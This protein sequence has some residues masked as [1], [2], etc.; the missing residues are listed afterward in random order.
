[1]EAIECLWVAVDHD[2]SEQG[3]RASR[4]VGAR[5]QKAG[6]EILFVMPNKPGTDLN[7]LEGGVCHG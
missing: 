4:A 7:D 3:Q 5:W 1:M 2:E 6:R